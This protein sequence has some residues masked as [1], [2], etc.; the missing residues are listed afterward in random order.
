MHNLTRGHRGIMC[1]TSLGGMEAQG[2]YVHN[3]TRGDMGDI[4]VLC[5]QSY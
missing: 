4:E 2:Y 1:R 3:L 5:A